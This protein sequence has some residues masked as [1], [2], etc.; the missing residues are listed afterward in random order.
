M[1]LQSPELVESRVQ[2]AMSCREDHSGCLGR[3]KSGGEANTQ[4]TA[5][6][7]MEGSVKGRVE[8]SVE[9]RVEGRIWCDTNRT[10]SMS[11]V[12][13]LVFKLSL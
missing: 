9:G 13:I 2:H 1:D 6:S 11:A 12:H 7:T 10:T 3:S 4:T 8:G 5:I